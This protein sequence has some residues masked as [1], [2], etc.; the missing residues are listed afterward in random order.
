MAEAEK[1]RKKL[2]GSHPPWRSA[3]RGQ[4]RTMMLWGGPESSRASQVTDLKTQQ[5]QVEVKEKY[6]VR[7]GCRPALEPK[8]A[9]GL[10]KTNMGSWPQNSGKTKCRKVALR[11]PAVGILRCCSALSS[12]RKP[13]PGDTRRNTWLGRQSP[14]ACVEGSLHL[15]LILR[16]SWRDDRQELCHPH[17]QSMKPKWEGEQQEVPSALR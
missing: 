1:G 16:R 6:W 13:A 10:G 7:R 15:Q 11:A 4:L 2:R 17:G 5:L 9:E 14:K 3:S 12:K 8:M